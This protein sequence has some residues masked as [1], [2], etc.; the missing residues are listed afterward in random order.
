MPEDNLNTTKSKI[1][2]YPMWVRKPFAKAAEVDEQGKKKKVSEVKG[3]SSSM[4]ST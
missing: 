4:H 1:D 2:G 3:F